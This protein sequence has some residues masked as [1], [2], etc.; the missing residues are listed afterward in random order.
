MRRLL[1]VMALA[2]AISSATASGA[3][4][5]AS[6]LAALTFTR[7]VG[8]RESVWV[9]AADGSHPREV[10]ANG[11]GGSLSAD[12][13][14]LTFECP[15]AQ[16]GSSFALLFLVDLTTGETRPLGKTS[17]NER[18]A[19]IGGRIAVSQPGGLF[20]IDA[21]SG[22]RTR[23]LA[24]RVRS[25]D[26][27]PDGKSIVLAR[28]S[29]TAGTS[30]ERSDI[31]LLRLSG[32]VLARLTNDG[33]SKSPIVSRTG[34][35]YV[36][37]RNAYYTPAPEAWLMHRDGSGQRLL[38]RCCESRAWRSH[39]DATQGYRTVAVST[40]GKN[41]LVCGPSS[42]DCFPMAIDLRSGRRHFFNLLPIPPQ[43][44]S[45]ALDLT[46]D[47]RTALVVVGPVHDGPGRWRLYS[48][49]FAGGKSTLVALDAVEGRW[50][51]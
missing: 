21:A 33:H 32:H 34:I 5:G 4:S 45:T 13:R 17:G 7:H 27:A 25:L 11:Y 36:R 46:A 42:I 40:D 12:G 30:Q 24:L 44:T 49:P 37:F 3:P 38:A 6:S 23:L 19:P 48:V 2:L 10:T 51:R 41:L 20:M 26:F 16:A 39:G 43:E 31:F 29:G 14:W 28:G 50:R 47:G 1:T 35:A 8:Q 18:W 22:R 15:Q 9:A